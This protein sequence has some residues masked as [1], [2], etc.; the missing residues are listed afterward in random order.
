MARVPNK[1]GGASRRG[2]QHAYNKSAQNKVSDVLGKSKLST[3]AMKQ[4]SEVKPKSSS[5]DFSKNPKFEFNI[6]YGDTGFNKDK[7]D[8]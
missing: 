8:V 4:A 2:Y 7:L 3:P 5:R 1:A 6:D